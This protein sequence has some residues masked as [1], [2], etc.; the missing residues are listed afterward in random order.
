MAFGCGDPAPPYASE[1]V[2]LDAPP[3]VCPSSDV[4]AA[5]LDLSARVWGAVVDCDDSAAWPV[6]VRDLP[7]HLVG[8]AWLDTGEV[9]LDPTAW[10]AIP[11]AVLAHELGHVVGYEHGGAGCDLMRASAIPVGCV[12]VNVAGRS[13]LLDVGD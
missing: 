1:P 2:R 13:Y 10:D 6:G 8:Q 12:A 7:S 3:V 9:W 4:T 5:E 11:E